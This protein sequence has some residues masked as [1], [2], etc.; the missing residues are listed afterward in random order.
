MGTCSRCGNQIEF[1]YV[2][3]RC[4]PLHLYG[5]CVSGSGG[6]KGDDY[7]GHKISYESTC[8]CTHCPEC[9]GEVFFIR[10]NGGSVWVDPPLGPPWFKHAC[11]DRPATP[12]VRA[13]LV[14][15]YK[16][17]IES[18]EK[19]SDFGLVL[20]I[21][22]STDVDVSKRYTDITFE[23][24]KQETQIIRL[25]HN[26]GYLLGRLCIHDTIKLIIWP[27][28]EPHHIFARYKPPVAQAK[29]VVVQ[30]ADSFN[31]PECGVKLNPKNLSRHLRRQHGIS[32]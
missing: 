15:E 10:H 20:G 28:E 6:S 17:S 1:R 3:G 8:F 14:M 2:D 23:T 21:V 30:T 5:G 7:S 9:R 12:S 27:V 19:D 13:S 18:A 11:F 24:G 25:Q 31:C 26:A 22:K 16:L 32:E 4:I 29:K